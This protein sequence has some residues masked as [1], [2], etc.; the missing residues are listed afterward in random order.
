[1]CVHACVREREREKKGKLKREER[2][3]QV[4]RDINKQMDR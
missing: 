4:D 3:R 2:H 1:M